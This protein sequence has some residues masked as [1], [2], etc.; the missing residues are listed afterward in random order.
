[1]FDGL[2]R[3]ESKK[4]T[5]ITS[6]RDGRLSTYQFT[7]L[8]THDENTKVQRPIQKIIKSWIGQI[9]THFRPLL[10]QDLPSSCAQEEN[11]FKIHCNSFQFRIFTI[12]TPNF[13]QEG[14]W[15]LSERERVIWYDCNI[16]LI[17][18]RLAK[19][20]HPPR[21]QVTIFIDRTLL[22]F[23]VLCLHIFSLFSLLLSLCQYLSTQSS[24]RANC[25]NE[26]W[27]I[28]GTFYENRC[29]FPINH[30]KYTVQRHVKP[31]RHSPRERCGV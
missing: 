10:W 22:S 13:H 5:L 31:I 8:K 1:M 24:L 7:R 14:V 29:A 2:V 28:F 12:N 19:W 11:T 18:M 16:F 20:P 26:F 23:H 30:V 25:L 4:P 27:Q 9:L 15:K 6:R 21:M 17:N 3:W